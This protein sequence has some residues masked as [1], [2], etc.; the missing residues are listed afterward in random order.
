MDARVRTRL[1]MKETISKKQLREFGFLIGFFFPII[2]GWLIPFIAGHGFREWTLWIGIP[3]L[4]KAIVAP[5]FLLYPY[6]FWTKFG[7]VLGW[8]NSRI[9]LGVI[10]ILVLQPIAFVMSIFGYDPLRKRRKGYQTYREK[11]Q[12][13]NTDFTRIF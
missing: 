11:R 3:L 6:L 9:I 5:R 4:I 13:Q 12:N 2:I 8:I 7:Y 1:I 10:F